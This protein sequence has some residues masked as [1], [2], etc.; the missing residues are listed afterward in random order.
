MKKK[1]NPTSVGDILSSLA[2][3]TKLGRH[4]EH[5]Q[6]WEHWPEIAGPLAAHG[7]PKTVKDGQLRIEAESAVW[8]HKFTYKRWALVKAINRLAGKE[9]VHDIFVSLIGDGEEIETNSPQ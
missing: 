7:R 9:L 1:S 4:L 6:I 5:A 3:T 2:A 8:M